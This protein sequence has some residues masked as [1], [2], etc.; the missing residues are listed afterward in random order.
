MTQSPLDLA[1]EFPLSSEL[2][3][4]NHAAVAPWTRRA[5]D[6]VR[7][8]ADENVTRG[9]AGYPAWMRLEE[10]LRRNLARLINAPAADD[11]ALV[12]NTSEA[13]S[14]VAWG[15]DWNA[16]DEVVITDQEFPSNR[17]VW[18]SL[19]GQGVRTVVA[20]LSGA[21]SPEA[22]VES[23]INK[24]TR[25]VS[26]SSVQYGTGLRLDLERL[27]R[28]CRDRG[29]LF[30]VDAI[31]SIGAAP[32]DV[33]ALPIDFTMADGHKWMLGP[34]GLGLFYVRPDLRP[35]LR[36][37]EY[38]WHMVRERGDFDRTDWEPASDAR[39]FECGS[40]NMLCAHALNASVELLLE[41][42][43]DRVEA[44]LAQRIDHLATRL[45]ELPGF[46]PVTPPARD[47]RL[48]ILTF[49]LDPLDSAA[50]QKKLMGKGV[51]CAYRGGGIRFSPHF[52]TP[53]ERLDRAVE[54]VSEE[55]KAKTAASARH[56]PPRR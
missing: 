25:L 40:P 24:R 14:M 26:V 32:M 44:E 41:V 39:R 11:V 46:V 43:L 4:L 53:F 13:L 22:A 34:E 9:A 15:L 20:P 8:F 45:A 47:R 29:V 2:C 30:C 1:A 28:H 50:L 52:Y 38:G 3:Y 54:V 37:Y 18:E 48:G 31:Q 17:I 7:R 12:K 16:G 5:A 19:S 55:V 36:L 23:C 10:S 27:G 6:A 51:I 56:N 35:R 21:A 42:G 49:R 33:Q